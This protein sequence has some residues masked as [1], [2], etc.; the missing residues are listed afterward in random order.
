MSISAAQIIGLVFALGGG[1]MWAFA[2]SVLP[3]RYHAV[4]FYLGVSLAAVGVLIFILNTPIG[5][6]LALEGWP[7]TLT[8]LFG[9]AFIVSGA[10]WFF[11]SQESSGNAAA[12]RAT[13]ALVWRGLTDS[14]SNAL[15]ANLNAMPVRKIWVT[16]TSSDC[17]EL[18]Q[19]LIEGFDSVKWPQP[20]LGKSAGMEGMDQ[21]INIGPNTEWAQSLKQAIES[22]TYLNPVVSNTIGPFS[23]PEITLLAIGPKSLHGTR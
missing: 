6:R 15:R 10:W 20:W 23:D 21:G 11:G 17:Y 16:C 1:L 4:G 7:K 18:A 13:G 22:A 3:E 5:Q 9:A 14:E 12:E 8:I 19:D 2:P